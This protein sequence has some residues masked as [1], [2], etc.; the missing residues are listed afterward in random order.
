MR[1]TPESPRMFDNEILDRLSR[2][3][4]W[5]VPLIWIPGSIAFFLVGVIHHQLDLLPA[6]G[7]ALA[8]WFVWTFTEYILHR[9]LF[10]WQP[11]GVWGERMHFWVH[12]V[13]HRWHQD[14]YRLVMP[15][16]VSLLLGT[17]F[18]TGFYVL[19]GVLGILTWFWPFYAGFLFGYMVYDVAHYAIHHLKFK[20]RAF[21]ALKKHHL[22]HHHS[23][24]HADRK[25]G[26]STMLWDHVFRTY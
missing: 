15:P 9:A 3:P 5:T 25:F 19:A 20:G 13:H 11:G 16:S 22:L 8:G 17:L 23:P 14:R 26:V 7:L 10:H 21:Q 18:G 4:W 1:A 6:V 2:T 24:K 12:G